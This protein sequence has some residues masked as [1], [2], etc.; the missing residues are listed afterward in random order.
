MIQKLT[1]NLKQQEEAE[2]FIIFEN[3]ILQQ[4]YQNIYELASYLRTHICLN[5]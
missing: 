1:C 4:K 5:L 2:N 3:I